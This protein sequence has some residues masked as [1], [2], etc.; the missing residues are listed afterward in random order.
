MYKM[1]YTKITIKTTNAA[2]E[3]IAASLHELGF[4]GVQIED[5]LPLSPMD[6]ERLFVDIPCPSAMDDEAA[7]L[8]VYAESAENGGLLIAG[9]VRDMASILGNI[10]ATLEEWAAFFDVGAASITVSEGADTDWI[11]NWKEHFHSFSIGDILI[12]PTWE[13]NINVAEHRYTLRIDPGMAFGTGLHETTRLCI[14]QLRK[15]IKSGD[16]LL[17]IGCGSG[18]LS[19][20]ALMFGVARVLT[21]DIDENVHDVV[22][23]NCRANAIPPDSLPLIIGDILRD[24]TLQ[25]SAAAFAHNNESGAGG[26]DVVVANI[27]TETLIPLAPIASG[28]LK[29]GGLL[30]TSGILCPAGDDTRIVALTTAMQSAGLDIIGVDHLGEWACVVAQVKRVCR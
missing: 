25:N 6:Q 5:N 22:R 1:N 23:E 20:L 29:A 8:S 15:H 7:Y 26:Y 3:V 2:T 9:D 19:I 30:I 17:D 13:E 24:E 27:L 11:N 18:I 12:A 10:E 21:L 28:L 16:T 4:D 14:C